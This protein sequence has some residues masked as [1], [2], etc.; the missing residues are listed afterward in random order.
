VAISPETPATF[1]D[2][3]ALAAPDAFPSALHR[4]VVQKVDSVLRQDLPVHQF[5]AENSALVPAAAAASVAPDAVHPVAVLVP[6]FP[7]KVRDF[8]S[9]MGHGS[10]S[11]KNVP[12]SLLVLQ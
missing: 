3:P 5:A 11:A 4:G 2:V 8:L 6:R 1:P 10:P 9:V 12:A 7:A